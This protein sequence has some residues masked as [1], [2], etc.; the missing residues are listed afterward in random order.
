MQTT[1]WYSTVHTVWYSATLLSC[2]ARPLEGACWPGHSS[3]TAPDFW[4]TGYPG[5]C[6]FFEAMFSTPQLSAPSRPRSLRPYKSS[7]QCTHVPPANF[8]RQHLGLYLI[9]VLVVYFG[10]I[11][12]SCI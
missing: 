3:S 9:H 1:V 11:P 8:G 12:D 2:W 10:V 5:K 7:L 4:L 6:P